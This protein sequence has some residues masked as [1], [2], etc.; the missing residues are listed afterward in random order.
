MSSIFFE[1]VLS[2]V[3]INWGTNSLKVHHQVK[4]NVGGL[5]KTIEEYDEVVEN[6]TSP[7]PLSPEEMEDAG[8]GKYINSEVYTCFT[9]KDIPLNT[10]NFHYRTIL[11]NGREYE[12]INNIFFGVNKGTP[13]E[14]GYYEIVFA[15]KIKNLGAS[16]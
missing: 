14:D 6:S 5:L 15:R 9:T 8:Y 10:D 13:M 16:E 3:N 7:Q 1:D 4:K 11:F 2:D 12:I